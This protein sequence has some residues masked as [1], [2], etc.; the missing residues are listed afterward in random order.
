[1]IEVQNVSLRAGS[2]QLDG[3]SLSVPTGQYG[4]LMGQTGSGKTTLLESI[5]GLKRVHRGRIR[6]LGRDVTDLKPAL[7]GVAYLPQ[8]LA[9]FGTMTV[10]E[11]LAFALVIRRWPGQQIAL[12]VDE[13]AKRLGIAHLLD[14]KPR[15]L[16]GG[17]SQRVALG[18]ALSFHPQVLL[19]D[20]PMSAL[21]D[22]TRNEMY[23]L[24]RSVQ[25]ESGMTALH[26]THSQSEAAC[27]AD[28]L[29]VIKQ[30][31]VQEAQPVAASS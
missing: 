5:C 1:M 23:Q 7:R 21:D 17:E 30:G 31:Q 2:F 18:R 28:K 6:L 12:R 14:R 13:L 8:D 24:L 27:L 15:G 3:I 26:V 19:L 20:E 9:L 22:V 25:H 11:H 10:R 29:F 4:V 16:S